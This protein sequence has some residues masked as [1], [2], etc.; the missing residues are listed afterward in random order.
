[1]VKSKKTVFRGVNNWKIIYHNSNYD[2][3]YRISLNKNLLWINLL[4]LKITKSNKFHNK[5]KYIFWVYRI[6]TCNINKNY[7]NALILNSKD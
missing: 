1:M 5:D 2:K 3:I 4:V 7:I 6:L